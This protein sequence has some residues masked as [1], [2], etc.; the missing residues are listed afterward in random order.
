VLQKTNP[1]ILEKKTLKNRDGSVIANTVTATF[2]TTGTTTF[3]FH[4]DYTE[5]KNMS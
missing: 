3:C 2:L 5:I 1:N 4:K